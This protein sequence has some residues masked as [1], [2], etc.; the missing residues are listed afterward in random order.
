MKEQEEKTQA[1][2]QVQP[3]QELEKHL[4][5]RENQEAGEKEEKADSNV[6]MKGIEYYPHPISL[7]EKEEDQEEGSAT[8]YPR[9]R[10]GGGGR[11]STTSSSLPIASSL[12]FLHKPQCGGHGAYGTLSFLHTHTCT[13]KRSL[14]PEKFQPL[15][16][17]TP[18]DPQGSDEGSSLK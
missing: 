2:Q 13:C 10:A 9:G 7:D 6:K 18:N 11:T 4:I 15:A 17:S 1:S 5:T 14:E 16:V 8:T 3:E 12:T